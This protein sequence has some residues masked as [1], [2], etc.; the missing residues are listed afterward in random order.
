MSLL[1]ELTKIIAE[2][3]TRYSEFTFISYSNTLMMKVRG[4]PNEVV[5]T[6][7]Y[8]KNTG[9]TQIISCYIGTTGINILS[10]RNDLIVAS[11]TAM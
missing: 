5:M 3:E 10:I 7:F 2:S 1:V 4:A 9:I 11:C 6:S 8:H